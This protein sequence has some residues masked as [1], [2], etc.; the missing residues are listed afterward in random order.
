MLWNDDPIPN[1]F[2]PGQE[3]LQLI[4]QSN[5]LADL[6]DGDAGK[7]N[8]QE[9]TKLENGKENAKSDSGSKQ[10]IPGDVVKRNQPNADVNGENTTTSV[11]NDEHVDR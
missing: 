6:D 11:S 10:A 8:V 4:A 9:N 2:G 5:M 7:D 3:Y 1:T